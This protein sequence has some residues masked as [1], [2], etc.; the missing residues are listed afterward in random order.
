MSRSK[1]PLVLSP[2]WH[3]DY[4]LE[5]E[6]PEDTIIGRRFLINVAFT[7]PALVALYFAGLKGAVAWNLYGQIQ[8]IERRINENR[9]EIKAID[10]IHQEYVVEALK[11]DEAYSLLKPQLYVSG[12][13]ANIG[14]TRPPQMAI[15]LI[16][17][18]DGG[19]VV[20]GNL[21]ERSERASRIL[22]GYVEQLRKDP[23][24]MPLFNAIQLTDIDRGTGG[25]TLRF[26]IKFALKEGK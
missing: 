13:I 16:E 26:E 17:W 1:D 23:R 22:G 18:N 4:R 19:V 25:E 15:D 7:L 24:I 11:I 21:Q 3:V 10:A 12:F 8:E 6:L 2:H 5:A 9:V 20:R 14:R